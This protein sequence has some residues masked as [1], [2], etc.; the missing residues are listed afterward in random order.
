MLPTK[1]LLILLI[2]TLQIYAQD[3]FGASGE[4]CSGSGTCINDNMCSCY[5]GF[6]GKLCQNKAKSSCKWNR[7]TM[8]KTDYY[9]IVDPKTIDFVNDKLQMSIISP[10]VIDRLDTKIFIQNNT[11]LQCAFPGGNV[12]SDLDESGD[13]YNR[14]NYVL[15]WLSGKNCGWDIENTE[16]QRIY[17]GKMFIEQQE[18]LG[19]IR[20]EQVQRYLKRVIPLSVTF[21][22]RISLSTSIQS[23]SPINMFTAITRQE[24]VE[25]P[26]KS[27]LFEFITSLPY[28][29]QLD[30]T[31]LNVA[32]YPIG[33][34]PT[35]KDISN[36]CK[37]NE[38]CTQRFSMR[39]DVNGACS[40]TGSYKMNFKIKCHPLITNIDDCPL[41]TN[42]DVVV[43]ISANSESFCSVV[44]INI[45]LSGTL[46]AYQDEFHKI[47]KDA[48]LLGQSSFFKAE[49]SS[50]KATLKETK[51]VR[52][53]WEK[54]NLTKVVYDN[55]EITN[56]GRNEKF[57]LGPTGS[58]DAAF[59]FDLEKEYI[60]VFED[61]NVDVKVSALLEVKYQSIDGSTETAFSDSS[62]SILD[63]KKREDKV[64]PLE[65]SQ[66]SKHSEHIR[67]FGLYEPK[68]NSGSSLRINLLNLFL[69]I[70][71]FCLFLM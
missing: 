69:F 47:R 49:V 63:I 58:N 34:Q 44:N 21:Q 59:K 48:F 53:Q 25:G 43:E 12:I 15:P 26:P 24:Y 68:E 71:S 35:L 8:T 7:N 27:G 10:L 14:F 67:I 39:L 52:V 16:D 5:S 64:T 33:L 37:I 29:F 3:C 32:E 65:G 55:F 57:E 2:T 11:Y 38:P 13:C 54:G 50:P 22:T 4:A 1:I 6:G 45:N 17:S 41:T 20:G 51:I 18:N 9:P 30:T 61:S 19:T 28:P 31:D 36:E 40:F 42:R 46:K 23:T 66:Q 70:S 60:H 56:E 62:F